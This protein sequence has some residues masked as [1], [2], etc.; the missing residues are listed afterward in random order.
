MP[1]LKEVDCRSDLGDIEQVE[2]K[3]RRNLLQ[4]TAVACLPGV[5]PKG[6]ARVQ[7]EGECAA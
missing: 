1:G 3:E 2:G 5:L 4:A 7:V 6:A